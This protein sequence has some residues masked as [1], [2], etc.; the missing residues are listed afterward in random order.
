MPGIVV[1]LGGNA[2]GETV[3]EQKKAVALAARTIVDIAQ[4][5][6]PLLI[7]HGNGP[8]VG[9][10]SSGMNADGPS[11][12]RS[13]PLAECVAM[14]QGYIGDHLQ[15]AI[16]NEL[17]KRGIARNVCTLITHMIVDP[18]DGSFAKPTKPIGTFYTREEAM[19]RS[20]ETRGIY[21]EDAGRGW[22]M[23]VASPEPMDI[24][25]QP[26]IEK[27]FCNGLIV[28]CG[29]GGG[30]PVVQE[31]DQLISVDAV[32]DKDYA[33]AMIAGRIKSDKLMILTGTPGVYI[34]YNTPEQRLIKRM[35]ADEAEEYSRK[36]YFA[37][38]SMLPKVRA[39]IR[40]ANSG[41]SVVITSLYSASDALKYDVGTWIVPGHV[42]CV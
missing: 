5:G 35:T 37:E 28:I 2:L 13:M 7:V 18:D 3:E 42:S 30:I 6:E 38:G 22:R 36:G 1:A 39:G 34:D 29:G 33:A 10:I 24:V 40:F 32:I 41:G 31:G 26:V 25:E 27:L 15:T 4:T 20:K 21:C 8:Q 16:T 17:K 11:E 9:M 14:S 12:R 19:V 23:V